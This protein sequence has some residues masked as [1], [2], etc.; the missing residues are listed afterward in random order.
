ME[1]KRLSVC[2]FGFVVVSVWCFG[3]CWWVFCGAF[4]HSYAWSLMLFSVAFEYDAVRK[5]MALREEKFQKK[6][7]IIA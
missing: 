6:K 1:K 5:L 3:L 2:G 4:Q 7:E